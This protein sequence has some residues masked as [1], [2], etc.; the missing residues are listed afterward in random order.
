VINAHEGSEHQS[1]W[2]LCQ[3]QH[4]K[5]TQWPIERQLQQNKRFGPKQNL[6]QWQ[7]AGVL[8]GIFLFLR[9]RQ[10]D[11]KTFLNN[12]Q[13]IVGLENQCIRLKL[14]LL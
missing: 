10:T 2:P 11:F 8:L 9:L 5:L 13:V 1:A 12:F 3:S 7:I 4:Q 14:S 6:K